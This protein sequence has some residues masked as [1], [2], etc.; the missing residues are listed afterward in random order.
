MRLGRNRPNRMYV[1]ASVNELEVVS[2][3]Q[4]GSKLRDTMRHSVADVWKDWE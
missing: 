4:G 1:S 2:L 3:Y